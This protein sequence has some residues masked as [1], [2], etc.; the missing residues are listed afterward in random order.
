MP[1]R[2]AIPLLK[3]NQIFRANGN[4]TSTPL[5]AYPA[6]TP[7]NRRKLFLP[8]NNTL[9]GVFN[10][11]Q[12]LQGNSAGSADQVSFF[13]YRTNLFVSYF[14]RTGFGWRLSSNR[15]GP[16]QAGVIIP[17]NTE[18]VILCFPEK[19]ITLK[20]QAKLVTHQTSGSPLS[21]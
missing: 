1:L 18:T 7:K 9:D 6:T 15:S 3:S 2:T 5:V 21:I 19:T 16:D 4:L 13:D 17:S 10:S 20:G 8:T 12:L 11:S 14:Y